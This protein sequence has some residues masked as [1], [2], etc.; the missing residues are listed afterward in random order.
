MS[1]YQQR[2]CEGEVDRGELD[3][4]RQRIVELIADSAKIN[5]RLTNKRRN[6]LDGEERDELSKLLLTGLETGAYC[7][8]Y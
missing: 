5:P 8:D 4:Y 7:Y 3:F 6:L 1:E 2:S